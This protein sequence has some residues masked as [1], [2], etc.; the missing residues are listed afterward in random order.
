LLVVIAII[1]ILASLLL[2]VLGKAKAR[3][4]RVKC[5]G[6]LR[7]VGLAFTLFADDHEGQYPFGVPRL[8][9]VHMNILITSN[10]TTAEAW[11]HFQ[12]VSNYLQD[13]R[14]I[15]C[16]SD[17]SRL[18]RAAEDFLNHLLSLSD[19]NRRNRGLSYFINVNADPTAPTSLLIGDRNIGPSPQ[20]RAYSSCFPAV[21]NPAAPYEAIFISPLSRW[22]IHTRNLLHEFQGNTALADGSVQGLNGNGLESAILLNGRLRG[23]NATRLLFPQ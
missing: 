17:S 3:A 12:A 23:T 19:T 21:P 18:N 16:P 11:F 4:Q 22:S 2:P 14:V 1:A 10:V 9:N 20:A 5:Q 15:L 7:Q 13:A 8:T 6:N